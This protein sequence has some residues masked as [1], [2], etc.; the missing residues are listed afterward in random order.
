MPGK[1]T[2]MTEPTTDPGA[3]AMTS[4]DD[5]GERERLYGYLENINAHLG[6]LRNAF[7]VVRHVE[8]PKIGTPVYHLQA[9]EEYVSMLYNQMVKFVSDPGGESDR[10]ARPD[11]AR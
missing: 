11:G 1:Q 3:G 9:A 6:S 5:I 10:A 8:N 7:G 4:P 2:E